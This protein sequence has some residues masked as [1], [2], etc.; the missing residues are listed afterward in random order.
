MLIINKLHKHNLLGTLNYKLTKGLQEVSIYKF[1]E[2]L[3][4]SIMENGGI[5][6]FTKKT[7]ERIGC[8]DKSTK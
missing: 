7:T 3:H 5:I 8:K 2:K 4:T 1:R 6:L